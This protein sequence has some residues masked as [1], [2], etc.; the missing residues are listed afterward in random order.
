MPYIYTVQGMVPVLSAF[1][2]TRLFKTFKSITEILEFIQAFLEITVLVIE[3]YNQYIDGWELDANSSVQ[4]WIVKGSIKYTI[5][6]GA[7]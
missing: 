3:R 6:N 2:S 7:F 5:K 1:L 4:N